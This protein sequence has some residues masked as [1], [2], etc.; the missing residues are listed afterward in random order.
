MGRLSMPLVVKRSGFCLFVLRME[1]VSYGPRSN[2]DLESRGRERWKATHRAVVTGAAGA[3][4]AR[5]RFSTTA[6]THDVEFVV[7]LV[8]EV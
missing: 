7:D 4:A 1:W 8:E 5:A 2:Q 3:A 6:T